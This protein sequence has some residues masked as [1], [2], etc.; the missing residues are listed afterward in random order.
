MAPKILEL[1]PIRFN[2]V[3]MQS[4]KYCGIIDV[5]C[6]MMMMMMIVVLVANDTAAE[7]LPGQTSVLQS[8]S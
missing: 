2:P 1:C 4:C 5:F 3:V 6:L 7:R 8:S